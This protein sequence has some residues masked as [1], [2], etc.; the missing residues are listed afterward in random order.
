MRSIQTDRRKVI[1]ISITIA[2]LASCLMVALALPTPT[3]EMADIYNHLHYMTVGDGPGIG[4]VAMDPLTTI[5]G[6]RIGILTNI[7]FIILERSDIGVDIDSTMHSTTEGIDITAME[8]K[9]VPTQVGWDAYEYKLTM[10]AKGQ[11]TFQFT[12]YTKNDMGVESSR[13]FYIAVGL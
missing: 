11:G 13:M 7:T 9:L 1:A 5:I 3:D 6:L 8:Y 2:I 12:I 4:I 10:R